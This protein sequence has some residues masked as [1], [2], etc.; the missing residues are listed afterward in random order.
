MNDL[1]LVPE[2]ENNLLRKK[3]ILDLGVNLEVK[4]ELQVHFYT[5]MSQ[6]KDKINPKVWHHNRKAEDWTH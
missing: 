4:Q 5:L 1:L 6:E 2:E 3:L